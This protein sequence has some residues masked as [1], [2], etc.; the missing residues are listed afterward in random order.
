M[1]GLNLNKIYT[2]RKEALQNPIYKVMEKEEYE[3]TEKERIEEGQRRL[4]MPDLMT[5][6]KPINFVHSQDEQLI[7]HDED[8]SDFVF[9]DISASKN[10]RSR[11]IFVRENDTGV[12]REASWEERD[13]MQF[14]YWPKEGQH[15]EIVEM[16]QDQHLP[17]V[18]DQLRHVDVLD[19]I[20][21]QC[22]PDSPDFIRVHERVYEDLD[23]RQEYDNLHSTR[24]FGGMVHH[25]VSKDKTTK[26]FSH[27][28]RNGRTEDAMDLLN[29]YKIINP[30]SEFSIESK[31]LGDEDLLKYY[32]QFH[33]LHEISEYLDSAPQQ[34]G[35]V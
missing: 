17:R 30:D 31:E 24:H 12:L 21:I 8:G 16:L 25:Y 3:M 22:E 4:Q 13:R 34:S 18:F 2:P 11:S 27:L 9:T 26:F 6:R 33:G 35:S 10:L 29:L 20:N 32:V 15:H 19:F 28:V 7:N 5:R 1:T 14:M 23:Q